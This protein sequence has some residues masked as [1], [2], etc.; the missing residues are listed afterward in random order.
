MLIN[1]RD[2]G[3]VEVCEDELLTFPVGIFG[4]ESVKTYALLSPLGDDVYPKWLQSV[5][6]TAPCFIVF[7]PTSIVDCYEIKLEPYDEKL[8][9]TLK[10]GALHDDNNCKRISRQNCCEKQELS[11]L[12]IANVPEDF[13]KTTLN[14][15]APIVIN[16]ENNLAKQVVL[17]FD[18]DFRYPLYQGV[19]EH[20]CGSRSQYGEGFEDLEDLEEDSENEFDDCGTYEGYEN[21]CDI[22]EIGL[23]AEDQE[24]GEI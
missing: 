1:T 11:L 4:F 13:K 16:E 22:E 19:S 23:G 5:E 24:A 15:K 12:V 9:K 3:E 8:L 10:F 14:L 20:E 2:F 21:E 6:A 17:P 18:Y 7:E